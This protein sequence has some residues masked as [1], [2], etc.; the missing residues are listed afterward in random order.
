MRIL[1]ISDI[2][3]NL[4][5]LEAVLKDAGTVDAVW[6]LGDLVGYGP[7]PNE[8]V[9]L[10]RQLPNLLC[11]VGNHDKAVLGEIDINVFNN[12]ARVA[13]E[14]TQR[15]AATETLEYLRS[16][17][18]NDLSWPYTLTHGSP[19]QPIW[20]YILDKY[21]AEENFPLFD[22]SYCLVGHTHVPVIFHQASRDEVVEEAPDYTAPR[23]LRNERLI[24]NPGSV[25]Q[26]RDNNPDAAYAIL[27]PYDAIWQFK[28][29]PY[30]ILAT[31]SRMRAARLSERLVARL[32]YGW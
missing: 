10:V 20:E 23:A 16:L 2:H 1:I 9:A 17:P 12:D 13:I 15:T 31:Q 8:C 6:C 18:A 21:I 28:R 14:W 11:L 22:T 5:A 19:R 7:N 25:G 29:V 24:I 32:A 3:A 30:D 4:V 27:E 26:P